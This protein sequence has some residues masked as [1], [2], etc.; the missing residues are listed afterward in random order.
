MLIVALVYISFAVTFIGKD[1]KSKTVT[2]GRVIG[3]LIFAIFP[4][5]FAVIVAMLL[6]L[7]VPTN[8]KLVDTIEIYSLQSGT[9]S[10]G[11][12]IL[13]SGSLGSSHA[14]YFYTKEESGA[15]NPESLV[16]EEDNI[17]IVEE[18]RGDGVIYVYR[19]V[20]DLPFLG[21]L[22]FIFEME[23]YEIHVP[24]G[25]LEPGLQF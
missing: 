21:L 9:G 12:F 22:T 15:F 3:T 24:I 5:M 4:A 2:A 18:E 20:A 14:Y 1:V 13:G 7:F 16:D 25:S 8:Y 23:R 17:L 11:S 10:E 19:R 6:G